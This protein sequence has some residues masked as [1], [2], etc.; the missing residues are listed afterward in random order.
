MSRAKVYLIRKFLGV[1]LIVGGT[2]S[3]ALGQTA[4]QETPLLIAGTIPLYPRMALAAQIQGT[5][6]IRVVTDGK[7]VVSLEAESGPPMLVKAA[8][9]NILTWEFGEHKPMTFVTTFEYVIEEPAECGFSNGA[10]VL[11]L[12]LEVRI[13]AKGLK[14]CDPAVAIK[15]H[16]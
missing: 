4:K 6:K 5:V 12:P 14:T 3:P 9:D 13:S 2:L 11:N 1:G 8:K 15:P 16:L 7:R 10:S